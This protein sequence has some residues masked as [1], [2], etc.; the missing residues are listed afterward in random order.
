MSITEPKGWQYILCNTP[1]PRD[2]VGELE[3]I[4]E[5]E[6]ASSRTLD[7]LRNRAGAASCGISVYDDFA[8]KILDRVSIGDV[9]GTLRKSLLVRRNNVDMWSGPILTIQGSLIDGGSGF[10]I[11]AVGWLEYLFHRELA[12]DKHYAAVTQDLIAF[13]LL[14]VATAQTPDYPVPISRGT[15]NA[16]MPERSPTFAKG[17]TFGASIQKLSDVESG[18]DFDIHPRTRELNLYA[19][20]SY[21]TRDN[22]K[23][24]YRWGPENISQLDWS[25][26]GG[27][28]LNDFTA[29]SN[30]NVPY[31]AED[32]AS[33]D[34]YGIWQQTT[35]LPVDTADILPAYVNA[36]LAINS[37]PGVT[38]TITP[39]SVG[40]EGDEAPHLFDDFFIGDRISF[41]AK[42]GFFEVKNQGIRVFGASVSIT[43]DNVE[44]I[45]SLQT[46]PAT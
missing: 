8:G 3:E 12:A 37:Q 40:E 16:A 7:I 27:S 30:S 32:V 11:G 10:K 4:G 34:D 38:Y 2:P 29:V 9:R 44:V 41:T 26:N 17:D 42:E 36:E 21:T 20:D 14:T 24:G 46:S 28:T 19:W 22:I 25:E 5:I 35:N 13:D 23:L 31:S 33:K 45:S 1:D 18:F 39:T 43:D 15:V 6:S